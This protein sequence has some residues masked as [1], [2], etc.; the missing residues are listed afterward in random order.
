MVK[1]SKRKLVTGRK[2]RKVLV[3]LC[4]NKSR[5]EIKEQDKQQGC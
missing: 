2:G 1:L 4:E 3:V 5:G